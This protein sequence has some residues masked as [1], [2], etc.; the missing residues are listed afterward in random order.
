MKISYDIGLEFIS[1]LFYAKKRAV[2][3]TTQ[4]VV[5]AKNQNI[6]IIAY[7]IKFYKY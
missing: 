5:P 2:S 6:L 1:S 4:K 7:F 3:L